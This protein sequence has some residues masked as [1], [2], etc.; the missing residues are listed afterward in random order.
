MD[1][2]AVLVILLTLTL[3]SKF[4]VELEVAIACT[5]GIAVV[6]VADFTGAV[7]AVSGCVWSLAIAVRLS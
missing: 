7:L 1:S 4:N 2:P 3:K 5:E 6:V